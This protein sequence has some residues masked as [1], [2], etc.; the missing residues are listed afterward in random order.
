MCRQHDLAYDPACLSGL[1]D[2][3]LNTIADEA[4]ERVIPPYCFRP[5][6]YVD[7]DTCRS[8]SF[9]RV[10]RS[11]YFTFESGADIFFSYSTCNSTAEDWLE[12][13]DDILDSPALGGVAL[14]AAIPTYQ[15]P[16]MF[17]RNPNNTEE[18]LSTTGEEYYDDRIPWEGAYPKYLK[19]LVEISQGDIKNVTFTHRSRASSLVHP[20]SSFTASVQDIQDG[21]LDMAVGPFWVT[22]TL[23]RGL[24]FQSIPSTILYSSLHIATISQLNV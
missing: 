8:K 3:P 14:K 13:E 2:A 19:K 10:F 17:K 1:G 24:A 21:L 12:V 5:W 22:G 15:I 20:T 11:A 6:C 23:S 7:A 16:Y 9:E 4:G 18:I